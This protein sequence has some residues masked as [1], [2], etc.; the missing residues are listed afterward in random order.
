MMVF[1]CL[2]LAINL[3]KENMKICYLILLWCMTN[4]LVAQPNSTPNE[5]K[6]Y[7]ADELV[8]TAKN[9]GIHELEK[10]IYPM[11]LYYLDSSYAQTLIDLEFK[12][13]FWGRSSQ[14]N[15]IYTYDTP[16]ITMELADKFN[17]AKAGEK[18]FEYYC[19]LPKFIISD[20]IYF[21]YNNLHNYLK[22]LTKFNSPELI[23]KLKKDYN[24]WSK[25][26]ADSPK[27]TY[28]TSKELSSSTMDEINKFNP[29]DL[30]LDCNF[31]V[32]Q[33]ANALNYLNVT[34]FEDSFIAKLK[35]K[36][37]YPLASSYSFPKTKTYYYGPLTNQNLNSNEIKTFQNTTS[38]SDF[39]KDLKNIEKLF[40]DNFDYCCE[41]R[42]YQ[43]IEN[44]SKAYISVSRNN[45]YDFYRVEIKENKTIEIECMRGSLE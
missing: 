9:K 32:L 39:K 2:L 44:G 3:K 13:G 6:I 25:L 16:K 38:I 29:N 42:I 14:N 35:T 18:L 27:K 23:E 22:T 8:K 15:K 7:N 19:K 40:V 21:V 24:D 43:V 36:Q 33:I 28:S 37:T 41:S 31:I 45:G 26:A 1:G 4:V 30:N 17:N 34:G 12:T 10:H 20:T 11:N 5:L